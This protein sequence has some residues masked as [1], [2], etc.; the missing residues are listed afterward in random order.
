MTDDI[1]G[2]HGKET[3]GPRWAKFRELNN[4]GARLASEGRTTEATAKFQE[5][6]RLTL[7]P[8]VDAAGYDARARVLGNLASL[9]EQHGDTGEALRLA[10]E[11]ILSCERAEREAD[12]RYGTVAVRTSVLIH[13]AQTLQ[14]LGRYDDALTDLDAA[15]LLIDAAEDDHNTRLLAFSVHN[16]RTVQLIHL[17]HL[18][19]AEA[20]ARHAL[21]LANAHDPRLAAHPYSNL[22]LIAQAHNDHDAAMA[23][24]RTA[25]QIH[26]AAGDPAAAALAVANQGR[27]ASRR[28]DNA[29]A[30]RLLATAEQAFLDGEQPLRAAEIRLSRA[31][32][33]FQN[34]EVELARSLLPQAITTLRDAGHVA[35]LAEALG[36]QGD[37]LAADDNLFE[38]ENAYLEARA[39]YDATEARYQLAR[40]DMRR[41]LALSAAAERATDPN[42]QLRLVQLALQLSLPSALATDAIRHTYAPGRAREQWA[43]TVAIPAMAHALHLAAALQ[44]GALVAELLEHMSGTMSLHAPSPAAAFSTGIDELEAPL[45]PAAAEQLSFAASAF[46]TGVSP[47]FP[48]PEF[49]LPPRVRVNPNRPSALEPWIAE[50]EQRYGFAIRSDQVVDAW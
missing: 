12:D 4:A 31:H 23:Y 19:A 32:A 8:D 28:G 13:R 36:L 47:D 17:E 38:A 16:T 29:T 7:V 48:A 33:A 44:D 15:L 35:M 11:A 37:M 21:D 2:L 1:I 45:F 6:Y 39:I 9:A 18:E 25:E 27:A 5:A 40:T 22:A 49:S 20:A 41:A 50:T 42:E 46:V 3:L 43:A 24:L 10:E 26:T 34:D 30:A 14:L